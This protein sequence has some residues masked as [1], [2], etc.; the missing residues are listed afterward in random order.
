MPTKSLPVLP[1]REAVDPSANLYA[2]FPSGWFMLSLSRDLKRGQVRTRRLAGR[3]VV[4]FRTESGQAAAVDPYCPHMGAHLG[5]GGCVKGESVVCPFHAFR[6][7]PD[8]KCVATG[9]EGSPPPPKM[10]VASY[11]VRE[12]HGLVLVWLGTAGEQPT[13]EIPD[14][15]TDGWMEPAYETYTLRGHP[16]ETSENSVDFGHLAIVHGYKSVKVL[17]ELRTD[18]GHL[19]VQYAM[20]RPYIQELG[21]LGDLY[22]EFFINVI[23]LGYSRV[24]VEVPHLGLRTRHLVFAT[25]TDTEKLELT[26]GFAHRRVG[27]STKL[28]RA[29]AALPLEVANR[30]IRR[31]GMRAYVHDVLQDFDIWNNKRYVHPPQLAVGDGPIGAYRR[32]A[33]QFYPL[34]RGPA[35]ASTGSETE[36]AAD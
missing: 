30:V 15:D 25:P 29:L 23:G 9:Y 36:A 27:A 22:A 11:P 14:I 10:R 31:L 33:K 7:A 21:F 6:F 34:L 35:A 20:D 2:N 32:W 28:P 16:Q 19:S 1:S 3:D 13:F 17:R 18:P 5:K 8:G 26:L 24:E 12:T 4:V